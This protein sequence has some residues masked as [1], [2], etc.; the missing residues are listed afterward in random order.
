[1]LI[2]K[3][4]FPDEL[5]RAGSLLGAMKENMLDDQPMDMAVRIWKIIHDKK[6][7]DAHLRILAIG[8]QSHERQAKE[9]LEACEN[10]DPSEIFDLVAEMPLS[11]HVIALLVTMAKKSQKKATA[12]T[13]GSKRAEKIRLG[14]MSKTQR[15]KRS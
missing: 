5:G 8:K 10:L 6:Y 2:P 13:G 4:R 7:R 1:M 14:I 9:L 3:T 12:K 15:E 11:S